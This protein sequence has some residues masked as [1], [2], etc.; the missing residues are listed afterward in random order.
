[1][2]ALFKPSVRRAVVVLSVAL[3]MIL[4]DGGGY[5][6]PVDRLISDARTSTIE[7]EA[8]GDI[9][10]LAIDK[11]SLDAMPVWPWPRETY[12]RIIDALVAGGARD[13]FLDIDL[14][15]ASR[16]EADVALAGALDRAGGGVLLPTFVQSAK[17]DAAAGDLAANRPLPV[18]RDLSW[19]ASVNVIADPDGI[20]R[21]YPFAVEIEG[22]S[23]PSVAAF[24]SGVSGPAGASFE[25]NYAIAPDSVPAHSVIDL[26]EGRLAA[27]AFDGKSVVVGAHAIELGD[28]F[29]VPVHGVLPGSLIHILASETLRQ[30]LSIRTVNPPP[31]TALLAAL[32]FAAGSVRGPVRFRHFLAGL[33]VAG[34]AI[35][36]IALGLLSGYAV[37][38][39][40]A[41]LQGLLIGVAVVMALHELDMREWLLLLARVDK[42]NSKRVLERIFVDSSDA[43]VIVD[44]S[45]AMIEWSRSARRMF[46]GS[47]AFRA[48]MD[49]RRV[50]PPEI[51]ADVMAAIE[52]SRRDAWSDPGMR[53]ASVVAKG[54]TLHLEYG[55]T[56]SRLSILRGRAVAD[57][58]IVASVV[59]RDVTL[60]IR[61]EARIERMVRFD[62]LTGALSR[63]ELIERIDA[64][65]ADAPVGATRAVIVLNLDRFRIINA[66]LGR[67]V[68]DAL[69]RAVATRLES[70]T[71]GLSVPARVG[72]H[73][74]ALYGRCAGGAEGAARIAETLVELVS[75][76]FELKRTTVRVGA[77]AGVSVGGSGT[78]AAAL[79]GEAELA[80]DEAR[81]NDGRVVEIFDPASVTR[82]KRARMV[83]TALWSSIANGEL[84]VTYQPQ[85]R[86]ADMSLIGAEALVRWRHPELGMIGPDEF[87]A[88]AE[89]N[90]F[91]DELGRWVMERAARDALRWPD[92]LTV[93][94]NVSPAQLLRGDVVADA[95][96][97]LAETGLPANRLHLEITE[98]IFVEGE[99]M[100]IETLHDLRMMGI[101][102]ALD[103]FGSGFSSFGYLA[104]LPLDKIKLDRMFVRKLQRGD[105]NTA[106]VES[107]RMLSR[108]LGHTL[109]C[110]GVETEAQ[111]D[112][113]RELGCDEGQGYLFGRPMPQEDFLEM[114]EPVLQLPRS[115]ATS[116]TA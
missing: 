46:G 3:A 11:K 75:G 21:R 8:G 88:L 110:E 89:E 12:A 48:G 27:A 108:A 7:R 50:L 18:F 44:G 80:L 59:A 15:A 5:L 78:G 63:A 96:G 28:N 68:G 25:V 32:L 102:L 49:M 81:R 53:V 67:K 57:D 95:A 114:A 71:V 24:L 100:L 22:E 77:H 85:I 90:G 35:E 115:R 39:P 42:E 17:V 107:V 9:L 36:I 94:V 86:L 1:M 47:G 6:L 45:G 37:L 31:W 91:I 74:F 65:L 29:G 111:R 41:A 79:L 30:D 112:F 62:A 92:H 14:S 113:L 58:R 70:G 10:F 61:Q 19:M 83:E 34:L 82:Q 43:I 13:V 64:D 76:P 66:T 93:A 26:L 87:I 109:V 40:T 84:F 16:P 101:R 52:M 33:V 106:I 38:L 97:V 105:A 98:S 72:G 116:G 55:V 73:R 51:A 69:L 56:P 20:V 103:D 4:L 60:R 54:E 104:T 2:V 23:V 99:R